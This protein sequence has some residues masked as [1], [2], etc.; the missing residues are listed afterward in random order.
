MKRIF[1][2]FIALMLL[3]TAVPFIGVEAEALSM[4][5][6][7]EFYICYNPGGA[8]GS[9]VTEGPFSVTTGAVLKSPS[10]LGFTRNGYTFS[11]WSIGAAGSVYR[12]S[13]GGLTVN[14]NAQ[15]SE[16]GSE[17]S[18]GSVSGKTY[19][20]TYYPGDAGGNPVKKYYNFDEDFV[21]AA[22]P[23]EFKNHEFKG[24]EY[25]DGNVYDAG[26]GVTA[27]NRDIY[28]IAVWGSAGIKEFGPGGSSSSSSSSTSSSS[29][30]STSSKTSSSSKAPAPSSSASSSKPVSSS[31]SSSI[32]SEIPESSE[33]VSSESSSSVIET[34]VVEDV[35]EPISLAFSINGDIPVTKIEFLLKKDVGMNPSLS[36]IPLDG[37]SVTD[38]AAAKFIADGDAL[39]AFD[40]SLL[41]DGMAYNG[42]ADGTVIYS[43]NGTQANA[44]SNYKA[45][46]FAMAHTTELA[47]YSGEYYITDGELVY[48]YNPET[49]FRTA[50]N[51]VALVEEDG[52]YRLVIKDATG[53]SSFAYKASESTVVEIK[54]IPSASAESASIDVSS[55]SPVLLVQLEVGS[56]KT[57]AGGIP[58]WVWII[59][60]VLVI[61]IAALVALFLINRKNE[62]KISSG[63][64]HSV[65]SGSYSGITGFDDEE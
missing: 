16:I 47:S 5:S 15:W 19:C 56:G 12:P 4:E 11:K 22:C 53:L 46:V 9:S 55:L 17:G 39:S 59:V 28:F 49:D 33:P 6:T 40:I 50:V 57:A 24:W 31:S 52:V 30:S 58:V 14:A 18:S 61:L 10:E 41:V 44:V 36:I 65:S 54:L 43:L 2:I 29:S 64:K 60:G 26:R 51:N 37:Y 42:E 25:G 35:F 63:E 34:P 62:S 8:N 32:S 27:P 23:F 21:L 1:S 13:R 3:I 48:L 7:G 38:E 45:Y 20:V